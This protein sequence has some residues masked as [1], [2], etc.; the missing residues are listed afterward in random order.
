[1]VPVLIKKCIFLRLKMYS[2]LNLKCRKVFILVVTG[3]KL[4]D[5]NG[6]LCCGSGLVYTLDNSFT[7]VSGKGGVSEE[8]G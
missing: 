3:V 1:M 8:G 7:K 2:Y 5:S 6:G 4:T